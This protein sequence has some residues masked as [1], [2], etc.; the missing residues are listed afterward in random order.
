MLLNNK[1]LN[2]IINQKTVYSLSKIIGICI[3]KNTTIF[4][5]VF[6]TS[7]R[8]RNKLTFQTKLEFV[9]NFYT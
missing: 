5:T 7:E 8:G 4:M 3:S 6:S 1:I 9:I 2:S